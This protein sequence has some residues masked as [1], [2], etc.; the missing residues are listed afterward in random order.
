MKN[1]MLFLLLTMVVSCATLTWQQ[2]LQD[3]I[4]LGDAEAV[5]SLLT[6]QP[7]AAELNEPFPSGKTPLM[8]AVEREAMHIAK[9]LLQHGADASIPGR[10]G[11]QPL[12]LAAHPS[13][14]ALLLENGASPT[15]LDS[16]RNT[17]LHK[18]KN[19]E[20]ARLLLEK[21]ADVGTRNQHDF[22][23]IE[24][25]VIAGR[26]EVFDEL[27]HNWVRLTAED[28]ERLRRLGKREQAMAERLAE[29][30]LPKEVVVESPVKKASSQS[31]TTSPKP[32]AQV[33]V[34]PERRKCTICNN[35]G[36]YF[37][38]GCQGAGTEITWEIIGGIEGWVTRTCSLC[39]GSGELKCH[40]NVTQMLH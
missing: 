16:M 25:A 30:Q 13:M 29:Y 15:A 26:V 39:G 33:S 22:T 23:P 36:Q 4:F 9:L 12:H 35:T 7:D 34:V 28:L 8:L 40:H 1:N 14:A 3:A 27:A 20:V 6:E 37:C 2:Q 19:A 38:P 17:P 18:A 10:R 24:A 31:R 21:G 11:V 32:Q 5:K